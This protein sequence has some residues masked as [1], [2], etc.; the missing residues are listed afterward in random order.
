MHRYLWAAA[1]WAVV[2]LVLPTDLKAVW[3]ALFGWASVVIASRRLRELP[4]EVRQPVTLIV[5]A[6]AS[7]LA[8]GIVRAIDGAVRGMDYP[9]PSVADLFSFVSL[10]LFLASILTIVHRRVRRFT[11]DPFLDAVVGGVAVAMLQWSIILIPYLQTT[12]APEA[13]RITNVVYAGFSLLLVVAAV[14]ALVSGAE[15]STS[16]RFL[17]AGLLST[18]ALDLV[19]TLVTAGHL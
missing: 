17:A 19:A 14:L 10:L 6:G 13:Q 1:V 9:F 2:F 8:G 18:F 4:S 7:S 15:R 16:N 12:T 5:I 11:L 3:Y